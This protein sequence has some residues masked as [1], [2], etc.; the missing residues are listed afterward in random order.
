MS[1]PD[2]DGARGP[3]RDLP[4]LLLLALVCAAATALHGLVTHRQMRARLEGLVQDFGEGVVET[5]AAS[6]RATFAVLDELEAELATGLR[7]KGTVLA[8]GREDPADL[9]RFAVAAGLRHVLLFEDDGTLIAAGR[10]FPAPGATETADRVEIGLVAA[11]RA[12][13]ADA[14]EAPVLR[15]WTA[16]EAGMRRAL[17]LA[18]PLATGT[19]AVLVQDGEAFARVRR[20]AGADAMARRL[21]EET[22]VAYVRFDAPGP[23][24]VSDRVAPFDRVVELPRGRT[25]RLLVGIDRTPAIEALSIQ[26]RAA[27]L[28]GALLVF[29]VA[30]GAW[31]VLRLRRTRDA[32]AER[33]RRD[34]RLAGLGRL[35]A[36]IAHEVRNPL[37]AIG[38][39]VQRIQREPGAPAEVNRLAGVVLDESARLNRTV[40][41]VLSY[42]R[43]APPRLGRV[44]AER[45]LAAVE[46]LAR[47][48]AE[49]KGVPL[50]VRAPAALELVCDA[51]LLKGAVWN[52]VRN[53]VESSPKGGRVT[54]VAAARGHR[55]EIEVTDA[56]SGVPADRRAQLFEPFRTDRPRG[57][58]LGLPLALAAAQAHGGTIEVDEPAGGGASFR[59]VLPAGGEVS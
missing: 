16:S 26:A 20:A 2:G 40:E 43:P 47:P 12:L 45:L 13:A 14:R 54:V 22:K 34:E 46:A 1:A 59:I 9:E 33:V 29:V 21:E 4:V 27:F 58:G 51:D 32:L 19:T 39:A 17:A 52:L 15:E 44:S 3:R 30:A 37:N 24:I 48:E 38:L 23:Q 6:L 18:A 57:V 53:A 56:G 36:A 10:D 28:H 7:A 42:A 11:A 55:A 41:S 31:V 8:E 35:A 49:A 50:D 5:T 25:G